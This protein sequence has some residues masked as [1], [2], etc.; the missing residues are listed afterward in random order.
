MLK[1]KIKNEKFERM[2]ST[3]AQ[4]EVLEKMKREN[5][6]FKKMV[7][8]APSMKWDDIDK[9]LIIKHYEPYKISIKDITIL[10]FFNL[11]NY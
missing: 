1:E 11:I 7:G 6:V 8:A 4:K 10:L 9:I 3:N 2:I 5:M